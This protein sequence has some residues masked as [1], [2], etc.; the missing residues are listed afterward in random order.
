M[1]KRKMKTLFGIA[2]VTVAVCGVA[3]AAEYY[4][5]S[6]VKRLDQNLYKTFDG[7][8]LETQYCYHYTYGEEAVLKWEGD[9]G[10]NTIIWADDT[11]C[12]VKK[13]WK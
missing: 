8:Y 1:S 4:K 12:Q 6:G 7:V 2:A 11:T 10:S 9:Y 5:L 3:H 13:I